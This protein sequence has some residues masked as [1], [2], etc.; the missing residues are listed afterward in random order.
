MYYVMPLLE[1]DYA[2]TGD[3]QW[4]I[5]RHPD[6]KSARSIGIAESIRK[7]PYPEYRHGRGQMDGIFFN[8]IK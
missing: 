7:V 1:R 5:E 6:W 4:R 3:E 2:V 8:R